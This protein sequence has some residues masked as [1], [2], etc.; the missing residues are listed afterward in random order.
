[1]TEPNASAPG[2]VKEAKLPRRDWILL[3]LLGL[4]TIVVMFVSFELITQKIFPRSKT[5][6]E[7]CMMF[8][9]PST[10]V[11]GTPNSVCWEKIA[12]GELTAYR[13]N[14]SGYRSSTEF[15]PKP[16]GTYRIVM[17]G[18]SFAAGMPVPEE[19][20]FGTLLP[21]ELSWRTGR[22]VELYNEG[23]PYRYLDTVALHY[24][25]VLKFDPDMILWII[26]RGDLQVMHTDA[27]GLAQDHGAWSSSSLSLWARA[28]Q[29][30][31]MA[32]SSKSFMAAIVEM[33][34]HSQTV[35][36]FEH[37]LLQSQS[38]NVKWYL[39][40]PDSEMGYLRAQPSAAWQ[41]AL[42][43]FDSDAADIGRQANT[44]G[45]PLVAVFLPR[46]PQAAMIS[47]G[48]WPADMDPYKLDDNLRSI[49]VSHG[50]IYIDIL[51]DFR[52]I[53]NSERGFY[54][55]EGHPNPTG[56]AIISRLLAKQLTSGVVPALKDISQQP[57]AQEQSR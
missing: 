52:Y 10:G 1:M 13:M 44:A 5:V 18:T 57:V 48:E 21:K 12:E 30:L 7:D 41:M 26:T 49:V 16:P 2:S 11:R 17:I 24:N 15:G 31:K 3:P 4:L 38:Q 56:Q 37:F 27:N 54:P 47:M 23:N 55:V 22:K 36:L 19:K 6:G 14:S 51:P 46:A 33:L 8:D 32:F 28:V 29:R 43:E 40:S 35:F 50:G 53:P 20:T 9:D 25:E 42:R 45:V 34:R 39:H